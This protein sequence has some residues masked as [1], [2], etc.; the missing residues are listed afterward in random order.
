MLTEPNEESE[1]IITNVSRIEASP[2]T[3]HTPLPGYF[4]EN[5]LSTMG[6]V[7]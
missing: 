7:A 5:S 3:A 2:D 1:R 6:R 4:D